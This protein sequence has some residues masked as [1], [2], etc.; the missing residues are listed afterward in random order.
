MYL[1]GG[2][3][4]SYFIQIFSTKYNPADMWDHELATKNSANDTW[5]RD[6]EA[7]AA[8]RIKIKS[9]GQKIHVMEPNVSH[10]QRIAFVM[11]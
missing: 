6:H 1:S 2:A 3:I 4:L 11:F 5:K 9:G 7:D 8:D 10:R